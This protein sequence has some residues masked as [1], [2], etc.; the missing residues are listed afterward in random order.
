[1]KHLRF[2][3][4]L[5]VLALTVGS[6]SHPTSSTPSG[7]D[8]TRSHAALDTT[9]YGW[10]SWAVHGVMGVGTINSGGGTKSLDASWSLG[11]ATNPRPNS[12]SMYFDHGDGYIPFS[13]VMDSAQ[14][15]F[16]RI[17]I[18]VNYTIYTQNAIIDSGYN[19]DLA[20][21]PFSMSGDTLVSHVSLFANSTH[22]TDY[23]W[24][25][26]T[27]YGPGQGGSIGWILDSITYV[28]P[29]AYIDI[30]IWP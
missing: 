28:A 18:E 26:S 16:V 24:G 7:P 17:H 21:I 14:T 2:V 1:M 5:W 9:R 23:S 20:D 29:D 11:I 13:C 12:D 25:V 30:K 3:L 15:K 22:I 4:S 8:T 10:F 6:C 27:Y 19:Y